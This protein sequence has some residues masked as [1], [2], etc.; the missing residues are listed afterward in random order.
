MWRITTFTG[1]VLEVH[2]FINT[3]SRRFERSVCWERRELWL[4]AGQDNEYKFVIHTK[5]MPAR[6]THCV[7]L[8][9]A[10][11]TVLG[12]YNATTGA[13][14][15]YVREDP[16]YLTRRLDILAIALLMPCGLA[17]MAL[18]YLSGWLVLTSVPA[19]LASTL[20]CRL[21]VR[22]RLRS[23]VDDVLNELQIRQVV[24]PIRSVG[25]R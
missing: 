13:N 1:T 12:L 10:G 3:R 14:A 17:G 9:L 8:V 21:A 2:R 11:M 5:L 15:N 25:M 20:I 6:K 24:R 23:A 4:G 18:G 7:T 19:Y 16:P 22:R